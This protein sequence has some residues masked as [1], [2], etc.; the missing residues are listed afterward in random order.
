MTIHRFIRVAAAL[1]ILSSTVLSQKVVELQY[2]A[3]SVKVFAQPRSDEEMK[4]APFI[5]ATQR[6]EKGKELRPFGI[7]LREKGESAGTQGILEILDAEKNVSIKKVSLD[8]WF[9]KES[10]GWKTVPAG[11]KNSPGKIVSKFR[12][13]SGAYDLSLIRDISIAEDRNLPLGKIIQIALS[14]ESDTPLKLRVKFYGIAEGVTKSTGASLIIMEN[15]TLTPIHPALVFHSLQGSTI[16]VVRSSKKGTA[17]RITVTTKT[18]PLAAKTSA[19][20]LALEIAGT[21]ISFDE[22]IAQQAENLK[23]YCTTRMGK[24]AVVT[25]SQANKRTTRP[26][27]TLMFTLYSHNIGTA[28]ATE[29]SLNNIIPAGTVY[30][31]GTAEGRGTEIIY[32]RMQTALPQSGLV[33]NITWKY[34]DPIY[35]GEERIASFKVLIQ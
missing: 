2:P 1:F 28:P 6:S 17:P 24:P 13:Q 5:T 18:I 21:S 29:N 33:T 26:G 27:D 23:S 19:T 31:E 10:A 34:S 14:A 15:D 4:A 8:E 25:L 3:Y 20:V 12:I 11:A 16:D 22:Q 35:P 30:L 7:F 32:T 9:G